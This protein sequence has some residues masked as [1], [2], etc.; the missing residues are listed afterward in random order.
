MALQVV[1][2]AITSCSCGTMP[3]VLLI[4]P[5]EFPLD[6][7]LDIPKI[8]FSFNLQLPPLDVDIDLNFAFDLSFDLSLSLSLGFSFA[9]PSIQFGL[10]FDLDLP[11]L[12]LDLSLPAFSLPALDLDIDLPFPPFDFN[13]D[14][15][16][17]VDLPGGFVVD[18][19]MA[20]IKD[21]IPILNV[22]PFVQCT[23][24][25]NPA[26]A[27][28]MGAPMP[29][30]PITPSPWEPGA[31]TVL[32]KGQPVLDDASKLKCSHGGEIKIKFAGQ[33]SLFVP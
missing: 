2:G 10:P 27:A 14:F 11:S 16:F 9:F 18:M 13:L 7:S 25:G 1:G 32:L 24:L 21:H 23:S 29:C 12:D 20:T 15:S 22:L 5:I 19:P 6:F 26:V 3:S 28:A 30:M 4:L 17:S 33:T 8:D 31:P